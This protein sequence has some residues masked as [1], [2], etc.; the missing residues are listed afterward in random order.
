M[1]QAGDLEEGPVD[2]AGQGDALLK[3]PVR[4]VEPERPKLGDAEV[5]QRQ[6][7]QVVARPEP[8]GVRTL[9]RA[10]TCARWR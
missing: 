8:R 6:R 10:T 7:T 4:A 3:V 1:R 5:D 9:G 2:P